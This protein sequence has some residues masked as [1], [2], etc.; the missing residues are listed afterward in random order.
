M[1]LWQGYTEL[2]Q[3]TAFWGEPFTLAR[4]QTNPWTHLAN[5]A[6][7][8]I[9][10]YLVDASMRARRLAG[11]GAL[12]RVGMAM[13]LFIVL[14]GIHAP[15]VDAGIFATPYMVSF[16]YLAIVL[17]MT[18]ELVTEAVL[19]SRYASDAMVEIWSPIA[20]TI[21]TGTP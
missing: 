1:A 7:V 11:G 10:V 2:W 12:F 4:G 20:G 5:V 9:V 16:A 18:Y 6:S 14:A 8:L 13:T 21:F 19:A 15:M 3:A 17:V